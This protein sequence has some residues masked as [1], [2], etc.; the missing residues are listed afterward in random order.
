MGRMRVDSL[1]CDKLYNMFNLKNVM[2]MKKIALLLVGLLAMFSCEQEDWNGVVDSDTTQVQTR[3]TTSIANF[4]PIAE[5]ANV[6][7]N[8]INVG[9]TK[10]KYLT[11]GSTGKDVWLAETDDG[12]MRQRWYLK[13]GN[14]I[15]VGGNSS[16]PTPYVGIVPN[17]KKE[18]P[19]LAGMTMPPIPGF[20][21]FIEYNSIFYN[22]K[23]LLPIAGPFISFEDA[24]YLQAKD[25]SSSDLKYRTTNSSAISRWKVVP[26]GE[27]RLVDVQYEK[28]VE[29]G[30]FINQKDQFVKGAVIPVRPEA[31]EHTITVSETV[32]ESSTFTET[33]GVTT[34]DQSSFNWGIQAGKAPLPV[35]NF[36]GSLSTTTTSSHTVGYTDVGTYTMA[37]SQTFKVLVPANKAYTIEVL[38][39][40][41]NTSLTYVA[42]LE[43]RDG[44]EAGE[45]F[46]IKGKWDGILTTY[47]YYNMYE[48]ETGKLV[49]TRVIEE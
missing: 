37:V 28:S 32:T 7:V 45:R 46:R 14:L 21:P 17:D 31:V 15:L 48:R 18:Y 22:I 13:N 33:S 47:L 19:I 41:Y 29:A 30:D 20:S 24:G 49:D 27:Y 11:V 40:S 38:K 39:M 25:E 12:S 6:P 4:D 23:G 3:A 42:T 1:N 8:V 10:Y 34:Q 16:I 2:L 26:V 5:L 35:I 43:K 44:V 9:N 36:G